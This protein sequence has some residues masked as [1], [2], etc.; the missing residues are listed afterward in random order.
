MWQSDEGR[1][2][3]SSFSAGILAASGSALCGSRGSNGCIRHLIGPDH[4]WGAGTFTR[5]PRCPTL[6]IFPAEFSSGLII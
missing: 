2:K 3:T 6:S 5:P 4:A 1:V